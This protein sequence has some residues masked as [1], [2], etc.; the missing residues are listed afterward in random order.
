MVLERERSIGKL[1]SK[2]NNFSAQME[3]QAEIFEVA[4]CSDKHAEL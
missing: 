1:R 4:Q 2:G 3:K